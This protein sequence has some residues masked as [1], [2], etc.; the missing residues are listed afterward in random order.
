M[1]ERIKKVMAIVF[2]MPISDIAESSSMDSIENWDSL[3]HIQLMFALEEEFE[4]VLEA[5]QMVEM[6][7]FPAINK[8]ISGKS[9]I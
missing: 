7:N 9:L 5:D 6:T 4:I 3:K 2:E 1:Q 8:I